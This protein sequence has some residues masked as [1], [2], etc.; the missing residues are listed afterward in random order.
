MASCSRM[1]HRGLLGS[2]PFSIKAIQPGL[3]PW[4]LI[5]R[6]STASSRRI[7]SQQLLGDS[8]SFKFAPR[9][10]PART[11][12]STQGF[13]SPELDPRS[14]AGGKSAFIERRSGVVRMRPHLRLSN[15]N[16]PR[17]RL[18]PQQPKQTIPTET[19]TNQDRPHHPNQSTP[20]NPPHQPSPHSFT[21]LAFGDEIPELGGR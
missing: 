15:R 17:H 10:E 20:T 12:C 3:V 21:R 1:R 4:V 11:S 9:G 14:L 7:G 19:P 13:P 18:P 6:R 8:R 16:A 2:I 5:H